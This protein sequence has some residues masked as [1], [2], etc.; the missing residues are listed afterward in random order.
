MDEFG[1]FAELPEMGHGFEADPEWDPT[2]D[3][4]S[5]WELSLAELEE[6]A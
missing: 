5:P 1:D 3:I 6:G 2:G 4:D